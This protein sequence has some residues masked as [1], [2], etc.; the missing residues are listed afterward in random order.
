MENTANQLFDQGLDLFR[1]GRYALAVRHFR[2]AIESGLT[3]PARAWNLMGEIF[4]VRNKSR[5]AQ[6]CYRWG[7]GEDCLAAVGSNCR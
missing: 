7:L 5:W 1:E 4:Y 6:Q 3:E 2:L